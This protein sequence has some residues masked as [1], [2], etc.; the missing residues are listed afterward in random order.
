MASR[1]F[2]RHGRALQPGQ[3]A[4]LTV[5]GADRFTPWCDR[6]AL[7]G[8]AELPINEPFFAVTA[9]LAREAA[10][11]GCRVVLTGEGADDL[12]HAVPDDLLSWLLAEPRHAAGA[13]LAQAAARRRLPR[14]GLRSALLAR[15]GLRRSAAWRPRYPD[16]L[17]PAFERR[18]DLPERW[19][20]AAR[21]TR[22]GPR[23]AAVAGLLH[24][25]YPMLHRWWEVPAAAAGVE[26]RHPFLDLRVVE[27]LLALPPLPA[28]RGKGLLRDAA[29]GRLPEAVRRRPKTLLPAEPLWCH[30]QNRD[31]NR[32]PHLALHPWVAARV[33]GERMR[34]RLADPDPLEVWADVRPLSLSWWVRR[35]Q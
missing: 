25:R 20:A 18:L 26:I 10:A 28:W 7:L 15:L 1:I 6:G 23:A 19:A 16:W 21:S 4:E 29:R 2:A 12:C 8:R 27:L 34:R 32:S 9:A 22:H 30:F 17:D 31:W 5:V 11:E 24:P 33:D 13:L 14:L 3:R 35:L